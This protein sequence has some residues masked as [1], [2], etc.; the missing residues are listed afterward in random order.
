MK[1]ETLFFDF[2]QVESHGDK[3]MIDAGEL[4]IRLKEEIFGQD[5]AI[6]TVVNSVAVANMR[7]ADPRKPLGSLMFL[8]PTGTGKSQLARSL[9]LI[10][11]GLHHSLEGMHSGIVVINCNEYKLPHEV[12]KL[13]GAPPGYVGYDTSGFLTQDQLMN[14]MTV[15]L[16]EEIEKADRS[17]HDLM[18]QVLD[19]GRMNTGK[20]VVLDFQNCFIIMTSNLG[21]REID[22]IVSDNRVGFAPKLKFTDSLQ[23]KMQS[24]TMQAVEKVF[25]PEFMNRINE[26]VI[27]NPLTKSDMEQILDKFLNQIKNRVSDI[28]DKLVHFTPQAKA[29]LMAKG[30][31]VRYGAR[32]LRRT[33]RKLV[34]YPLA[35]FLATNDT[36]PEIRIDANACMDALSITG[37]KRVM[38]ISR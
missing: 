16:L 29:V 32:A 23:K 31:D 37:K 1:P 4:K 10:L 14:P 3:T 2:Y 28:H 26:F 19:T 30:F 5:H 22:S 20:N 34:E 7:I 8:G 18:L 21:A 36:S 11:C 38:K 13:T 24:V 33:V 15:I 27:F 35:Q 25:S 17:L 9:A 6:E 12:S